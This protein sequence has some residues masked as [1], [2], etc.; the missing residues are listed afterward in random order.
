MKSVA[1]SKG[2]LEPEA[3][4]RLVPQ[5]RI[6]IVDDEEVIASTLKEFLHGEGYDVATARDLTHGPC[7]G[8]G[9]RAGDRTLRRPASRNRRNHRLATACSRS[10]QKHCS[11]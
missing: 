11:S 1:S 4:E 6:L 5:G 10:G 3:A 9:A 8:G 2:T 7:A